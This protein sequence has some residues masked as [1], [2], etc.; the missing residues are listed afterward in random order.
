MDKSKILWIGLNS[1]L[2]V[3]KMCAVISYA[4]CSMNFMLHFDASWLT[5]NWS[6]LHFTPFAQQT[7]FFRVVSFS[8][9]LCNKP[10]WKQENNNKKIKANSVICFVSPKV[11]EN[12][13]SVKNSKSSRKRW[14]AHAREKE[15]RD[16]YLL[17]SV[18]MEIFFFFKKNVT[19]YLQE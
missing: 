13:S 12:L 8:C 17:L 18:Y 14:E 7:I 4:V 6:Y 5:Q 2:A 16:K 19:D 15:Q 11:L 3:T 10:M 9:F 1:I